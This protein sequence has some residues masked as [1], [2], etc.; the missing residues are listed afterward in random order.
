MKTRKK[1]LRLPPRKIDK[2]P[3]FYMVEYQYIEA[4]V[5]IQKFDHNSREC[6]VC[7]LCTSVIR[8]RTRISRDRMQVV[9]RAAND[10]LGLGHE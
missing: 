4:L 9:M 5:I 2:P 3:E 8:L 6:G 7:E 10:R 1:K